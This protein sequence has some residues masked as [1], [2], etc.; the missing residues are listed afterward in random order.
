MEAHQILSEEDWK[1]VVNNCNSYTTEFLLSAINSHKEQRGGSTITIEASEYLSH[2]GLVEIALECIKET[3]TCD[4]Y[5]TVVWIDLS[6]RF[7]IPTNK[8]IFINKLPVGT[9]LMWDA[10]PNELIE[11]NKRIIYPSIVIDRHWT[12]T[13]VKIKTYSTAQ[14]MGPKSEYLRFPTEDEHNRLTWPS[15]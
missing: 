5:G 4:K 10:P 13:M 8:A 2:Q 1:K 12:R 15:L 9:K 3:N 11:K 6:G 7:I 14:W